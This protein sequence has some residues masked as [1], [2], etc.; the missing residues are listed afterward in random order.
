M[1]RFLNERKRSQKLIWVFIS[2]I[3]VFGMVAF[4]APTRG[5]PGAS[6]DVGETELVAKVGSAEITALDYTKSLDMMMQAYQGMLS[7]G[8]SA[9]T[10]NS[11]K[12]MGL[13]KTAL[14]SLIRRKIVAMEVERLGLEATDSELQK[15]IREQFTVDGLWVGFD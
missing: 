7:R 10:Y 3:V 15:R 6:G 1:L 11:L 9:V 14:N 4:Y 12:A 5:I 2:V 8:G 13:D